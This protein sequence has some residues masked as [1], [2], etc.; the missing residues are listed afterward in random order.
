MERARDWGLILIDLFI[1]RWHGE[2]QFF[3]EVVG[4]TQMI[5]RPDKLPTLIPSYQN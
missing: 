4:A 2:L 3:G 1:D 5:A